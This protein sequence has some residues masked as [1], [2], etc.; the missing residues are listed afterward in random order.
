[1]EH[2]LVQS[3]ECH[4]FSLITSYFLGFDVSEYIFIMKKCTPI[5]FVTFFILSRP[6]LFKINCNLYCLN[7]TQ[8]LIKS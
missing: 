3:R 2:P 6:F 4:H 1:M 5:I 7:L 8:V